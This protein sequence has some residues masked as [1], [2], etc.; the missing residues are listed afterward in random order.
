MY[1]PATHT[2]DTGEGPPS[3]GKE[4]LATIGAILLAPV[5]LV[6]Q[7]YKKLEEWQNDRNYAFQVEV[8]KQGP[9]AVLVRQQGCEDGEKVQI[10]AREHNFR[11]LLEQGD[12]RVVVPAVP[13]KDGKP[14]AK[15]VILHTG[16]HEKDSDYLCG[17]YLDGTVSW[18]DPTKLEKWQPVGWR[19][20]FGFFEGADAWQ[21]AKQALPCLE[22]VE[23]KPQYI[24]EKGHPH[25]DGFNETKECD[26]ILTCWYNYRGTI[27]A[28]EKSILRGDRV[29]S[30]F[31]REETLLSLMRKA[32][33]K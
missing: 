19:I 14:E 17:R 33:R 6:Y 21:Q 11:I 9:I 22:Q 24:Y 10:M 2:F 29:M 31:S 30:G 18:D 16:D 3:F 28:Y 5:I 8:L 4:L 20:I 1:D 23:I 7:G 13:L 25:Y 12:V 32:S 15:W 26:I 27:Y